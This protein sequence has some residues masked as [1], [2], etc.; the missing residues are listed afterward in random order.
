HCIYPLWTLAACS[1]YRVL[2][3]DFVSFHAW[4]TCYLIL[5]PVKSLYRPRMRQEHILI[6][7]SLDVFRNYINEAVK[8][9]IQHHSENQ[10]QRSET[11]QEQRH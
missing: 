11:Q 1:P 4:T 7:R 2:C 3:L 8:S 10:E 9:I 5:V 6:V